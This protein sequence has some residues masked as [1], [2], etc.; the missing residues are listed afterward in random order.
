MCLALIC[1]FKEKEMIIVDYIL[2]DQTWLKELV[3]ILKD[4]N[5]I[6]VGV[7]IPLEILE[8]R[9]KQ[10]AT[11]PVGH[12]RSHFDTVH[13]PNIYDLK[14]DSFILTSQQCAEK[15][16]SFIDSKEKPTAFEKIRKL[17]Q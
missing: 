5:V 17:L 13:G 10:R 4:C 12:A 1:K 9:E 3:T 11:S 2:Y 6:F 16:K 8:Q 7:Y 15:I 14:L